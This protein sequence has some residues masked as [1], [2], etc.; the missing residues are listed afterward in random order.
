MGPKNQAGA[1]IC[2]I[3]VSAVND[4][5]AALIA[6]APDLLAALKTTEQSLSGLGWDSA[7]YP[8]GTQPLLAAIRAAILKAEGG[9]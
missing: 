1:P 6:A 4:A 3:G 5:N 8:G 7:T 9:I 2:T